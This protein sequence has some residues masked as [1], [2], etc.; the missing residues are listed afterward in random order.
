MKKKIL[1]ILLIL[2]TL[3]SKSQ[4]NTENVLYIVDSIPIIDEPKEG[5]NTLTQDQID[6]IVVIKQKKILDSL[7]YENL[8]GII[9][10]F[11]KEYIKRPDSIKAIPT[12]NR[13]DKRNGK[14][15]LKNSNNP[16]SGKFIDYYLNGHKQGDG[17]LFNGKLKGKRNIYYVNGNI[18][19]EINYENG[20]SHGIDKQFFKDGALK[21]KG[22]FKN[23][24]KIGIWEMYYPNQQLKQRT[25]FNE[26]GKMNGESVTYYSTGEIKVKQVFVNGIPKKDKVLSKIYSLYNEGL[27]LDKFGKFKS[28]IKKYS[29]CIELDT[30]FADGYFARGTAKLNNFQF[31]QAML[32]FNKTL[33]IEPYFVN[34]YANRA[35]VTIR[36]HEFSNSRTLSKSKDVLIIASKETKIPEDDL[37]KVCEDLNK[38]VSL[39]DKSWIVLEAKKKHCKD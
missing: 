34:A 30:S 26:N 25:L 13:M 20:I 29:K 27:E 9:Y 4:N 10:V 2:V 21:Q 39:G 12:T 14:W 16:Y 36:K 11:T 35:F 8:D 24:E 31:D 15:Y 18:S 38:A 33:E 1:F 17:T 7:G 6:N 22:E 19:N 32:D 23:G 28:S 5:F 37:I 3:N